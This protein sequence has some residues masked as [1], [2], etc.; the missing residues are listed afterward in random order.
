MT[1]GL[2]IPFA[3]RR[4]TPGLLYVAGVAVFSLL[5]LALTGAHAMD[6]VAVALIGVPL[7]PIGVVAAA[8]ALP[9]FATAPTVAVALLVLISALVIAVVNV[10]VATLITMLTTGTPILRR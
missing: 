1:A 2:L 3:R 5:I 7:G 10:L 6:P 8:V 4:P 9:A